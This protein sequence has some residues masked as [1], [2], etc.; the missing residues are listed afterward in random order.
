MINEK[1]IVSIVIAAFNSEKTLP[2]VL[3]S[4]DR[5][6]YPKN[7]IEIIIVDGG[8]VDATKN[9]ATSFGCNIINNP[10]TEPVS[11]KFLGYLNARGNYLVYLDHDEVIENINSLDLKTSVLENNNRVKAVVGS[12]YKNP[13]ENTII[14]DYINEFG[15][16]FSFFIY[17]LSKSSNFFI[18]QMKS[19]Y[20]IEEENEISITFNFSQNSN[21]P[22][23]ELCA[24]GSMIDL[25]WM[26]ESFPDTL[27]QPKLIPHIF[28]LIL[29]KNY[30]LSITKNDALVHYSTDTLKNYLNKI[31]WRVKN[32]IHHVSILGFSGF[33]GR[34]KFENS[35]IR[36]KKYLFIPYAFILALFD[37]FYLMITRKKILFIIHYLLCIYTACLILYH[38][39][40]KL[41][42]IKPVL[43]SYDELKTIDSNQ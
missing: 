20:N 28:Y 29:T 23:I 43:K 33:G 27:K 30:L 41:I 11:A 38:Y 36:Y 26:K 39:F 34:I 17:R 8:S 19:R 7:K 4:I 10:K 25:S 14:N 12:G 2:K 31:H 5:Q 35:W 1:P 13:A 15:D 32:N 42:G 3:N 40:I 18:K 37:A 9:I 6:N 22:I 21:L 16:P 24:A